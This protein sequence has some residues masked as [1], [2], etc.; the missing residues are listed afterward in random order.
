MA[1]VVVQWEGCLGRLLGGVSVPRHPITQRTGALP[2]LDCPFDLAAFGP[3]LDL[4]RVLDHALVRARLSP[5]QHSTLRGDQGHL[6]IGK[7][8]VSQ[9]EVIRPILLEDSP[10]CEPGQHSTLRGIKPTRQLL[11]A[12]HMYGPVA[13]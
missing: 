7:H 13:G 11:R 12:V 9:P 2:D 1:P 6:M 4:D 3:H 8:S 5:D 10:C